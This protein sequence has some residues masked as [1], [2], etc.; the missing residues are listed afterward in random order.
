MDSSREGV[1]PP[2]QTAGARQGSA[3]P[4]DSTDLLIEFS[5]ALHKRAM[6]P[7]G[8]PHL[9]EASRRLV[10]RLETYVARHGAAAI[11]VAG[12]QLIMQGAATDPRS[13]L[14]SDLAGKLHR[15]RIASLRLEPDLPADELD[16]LLAALVGDPTGPE[17]PLGQR[18]AAGS[19]WSRARLVPTDI[20]R[21]RLDGEEGPG[22]GA[23][24]SPE[25]GLW[26]ALAQLALSADDAGAGAGDADDPLAV[27]RAIDDET[28]DAAYDQVVFNYLRQIADA[29]STPGSADNG[30]RQQSS[31]LIASLKPETLRRILERGGDAADRR[32]LTE[33]GTKVFGLEA[34]LEIVKAAAA[35]DGQT[36]SHQM[37]RLLHKLAYHADNGSSAGKVEAESVLRSNVSRLLTDWQLED[38]NPDRYTAVLDGIVRQAPMSTDHEPE[39][40]THDPTL[41]VQMG[42]EIGCSGP[43]VIAAVEAMLARGQL[44]QLLEL[45]THGPDIAD[46]A[47]DAIWRVVASPA[48]LRSELASARVDFDVIEPLALRLGPSAAD[49]LLDVLE[50]ASDRSARARTL[51]II[52]AL[53]P[54]IVSTV[55]SRLKDA[56]WYVQRN[57][58]AV[59]RQLRVWPPGFSAVPFARHTDA[60]LRIEAFKFLLEFPAHRSSAINRGLEDADA[61]IVAVVLRSAVEDCPLDALPA[62]ER[63]AGNRRQPA[64][65][66]AIAVRALGA[67]AEDQAVPQ[68]LQLAGSAP[69]AVSLAPRPSLAGRRGGGG[70]A[71]ALGRRRSARRP[72]AGGRAA[73]FR[74]RHSSRRGSAHLG[75]CAGGVPAHRLCDRGRIRGMSEP[76]RL[77]TTLDPRARNAGSLRGRPPRHPA[78]RG[79]GLPAAGR[80]PA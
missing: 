15:H 59:L 33:V 27:A 80:P 41:V 48:L 40:P 46:S 76:A 10:D 67:A 50:R 18:D 62:I 52:V 45:L 7:V 63:F 13:A 23:S 11:G 1:L 74:P 5:I 57:L 30:I 17:G 58:L 39:A 56:P 69:P 43:R 19:R 35:A 29:L 65:Q 68:L 77:L 72:G 79:G 26:I 21:L 28:A 66:R 4:K 54:E 6:Y 8:H 51:R 22:D 16:E 75:S 49:P 55:T 9:V 12:H 24:D 47:A 70:G 42:L 73:P 3:L 38:P 64:D 44:A 32:R 60:R 14:L 71:G 34:V 36:I 2:T 53:G 61:S 20:T 37:V 78:R 31:R 25:G